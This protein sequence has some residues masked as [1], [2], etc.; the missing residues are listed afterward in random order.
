M[1]INNGHRT[2]SG[3]LIQQVDVVAG[4]K[5]VA[6]VGHVNDGIAIGVQTADGVATRTTEDLVIAAAHG[7]DVVTVTRRPALVGDGDDDV[8]IRLQLIVTGV[9]HDHVIAV[10]GIDDV[11][12]LAREDPVSTAQRGN[13]VC[14]IKARRAA[15]IIGNGAR[16]RNVEVSVDSFQGCIHIITGDEVVTSTHIKGVAA[17]TTED[18]VVTRTGGDVVVTALGSI[19]HRDIE[20]VGGAHGNGAGIGHDHIIALTGIHG[21]EPQS[22]E[23]PVIIWTRNDGVITASACIL[24][25]CGP[26]ACCEGLVTTGIGEDQVIACAGIDIIA[27]KPGKD[28]IGPCTG[29]DQVV[30][31]GTGIDSLRKARAIGT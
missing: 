27:A 24:S 12:T 13:G 4:N 8:A 3:A 19:S 14:A 9:R 15:M 10:A 31:L 29:D 25:H 28:L 6:V 26:A 17:R 11:R 18:Q 21:V 20:G 7:D 2:V 5:V 16:A 23:N 30:I 22:G 1:I